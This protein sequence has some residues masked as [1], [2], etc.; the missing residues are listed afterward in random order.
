MIVYFADRYLNIIGQASTTLPRGLKIIDDTKTEDVDT[1]VATFEFTLPYG[2]KKAERAFANKCAA[3]GNYILRRSGTSDKVDEFYTII[4]SEEDTK[5]KEISIYA[6][7]AGL[8]LLNEVCEKYEA[9]EAHPISF[10]I[11]KFAYDSGF[12]IGGNQ[13][14]DLSRKLK[15]DGESTATER[16]ASVAT[17]FD[18]EIS[19]S[20]VIKGLRIVKKYIN[21]Y[22]KRGK[23]V[24]AQVRLN[25]DVDSIVTTK[26]IAHLATALKVTGGIPDGEENP[27]TLDGYEYDDGDIYLEGTY[28]KSRAAV[29]KWTRYL[30]ED[31][32]Y[33]GHILKTFTYDT[34]DQSTLCSH[35][36]SELKK[37][38]EIE[39]NYEVDITKLPENA[40]LGDRIN[41]IDYDG[42]LLLSAR[43]LKLEVSEADGTQKATLGEY[44]IKSGGIHQKMYEL[45]ED[46]RKNSQSAAHALTVANTAKQTAE[47]A[48]TKANAASS[49]AD[50]AL[51]AA[52]AAK[53]A[54]TTAETKAAEAKTAAEESKTQ[55]TAAEEAAGNAQTAADQAAT[56]AATAQTTATEAKG[57]AAA[58]KVTAEAAK[59][60][61]AAAQGE[62]DSLGNDLEALSNT[63]TEDY[64]K[65]TELAEAKADLQTQITQN[66]AQIQSTATK[67]TEID[68]TANNAAQQASQ[69]Q[70]K[71]E[72][73]QTA[74]ETAKTTATEA[75]RTAD[76]AT[77][78]ATTAQTKADEAAADA[79]AA[80]TA[81]DNANAKAQQAAS[82]LE[83]AK[84][85]LA[86]VT[87]RVDATEEEIEAAQ[88]AV[89]AA[90]AAADQAAADAA[91][92]QTTADTAKMNAKT[93][94]TAADNAKTAADNAQKAADAAKKSADDAQAAVDDLAVRVTKAE[95]KITQTAEQIEL[96]ATKEDVTETLGDYY[97]KTEADAAITLKAN[98]ISQEVSTVKTEVDGLKTRTTNAETSIQQNASDILLRAKQ[99][100]LEALSDDLEE[101]YYTKSETESSIDL[102]VDAITLTVTTALG[103]VQIKLS[104]DKIDLT[105]LVSFND[106]KNTGSTII[107]GSN[108][109]T[110]T[111]NADLV[112]S[113]CIVSDNLNIPGNN[114]NPLNFADN[115]TNSGSLLNLTNGNF[116][117]PNFRI[118][119]NNVYCRGNILGST[120]GGKY[121]RSNLLQY[122]QN[123]T[124]LKSVGENDVLNYNNSTGLYLDSST[125]R[126]GT[127]LDL[128]RGE[129]TFATNWGVAA[130]D[131][132]Y[133]TTTIHGG[134]ICFNS[135]SV[136]YDEYNWPQ[137]GNFGLE[138]GMKMGF[139]ETEGSN[140]FYISSF[141]SSVKL[142]ISVKNKLTLSGSSISVSGVTNFSDGIEL[143]TRL[144]STSKNGGYIDF[145]YNGSSSDYTS[146]I[147]EQASGVLAIKGKL[148]TSGNLDVNGSSI[149]APWLSLKSGNTMYFYPNGQTAL[150]AWMDKQTTGVRFCPQADA[151]GAIGHNNY[152][153]NSIYSSNGTIQTSDR[154]KKKDISDNIAVYKDI[155][156]EITPVKYRYNDIEE[157]KIRIGFI[158]Q[159]LDSIFEKHGLNPRDFAAIR[160]DDVDPTDTIPDGKVYG[161][162][163]EGFVALNTALIQDL[164]KEVNRLKSEVQEL[165]GA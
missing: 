150:Y 42:D 73:A 122:Y 88:A 153:W 26:S 103:D 46:F 83:T 136:T 57:A 41:I 85:N 91:A 86:N 24:G 119:G 19:Y 16:L 162:S 118:D 28:L 131:S 22:R 53:T 37:I 63:M 1:G 144:K 133:Y 14:A 165:K 95:T 48:Q 2:D 76:V 33:T 18:C 97:T 161:L 105:G 74:A 128:D 71:A 121:L 43:I 75:Q 81:A 116:Y 117:T 100:D 120:V 123:A 8:D 125:I 139:G 21:I 92:A 110:G 112:R 36:V 38:R 58:A 141:T 160:L 132:G 35:A 94:Q 149:N 72:A 90:Q 102:A 25:K 101:N 147:I 163:Y 56:D 130:D 17:Q 87:S 47:E 70:T 45:A 129:A 30:V 10:Y 109:T 98:E 77:T 51:A 164:Q 39:V 23:D 156:S 142:D 6:E 64:A 93:A 145:H 111:I 151:K 55:A 96:C 68:E 104:E 4:E 54:A 40:R 143:G 20:F 12:V 52:A 154:R 66:A 140:T 135:T 59:A 99:S 106:L 152:R 158:A 107:N 34:T 9:A 157:D 62:I 78:K 155:L 138:N 60:D 115:F 82:D 31:G 15:W 137:N 67:V 32:D 44:L 61:A 127:M 108:I 80:Q 29:A 159:D 69:A 148:E 49:S 3:V 114:I 65:K 27:I 7:D 134:S 5:S 113:G 13:A 146:R 50:G 79:A 124:T 89:N 11:N 126:N 84:T